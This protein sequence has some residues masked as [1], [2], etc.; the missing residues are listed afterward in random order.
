MRSATEAYEVIV[1]DGG[2]T[3]RG[4]AIAEACGAKIIRAPRGRGRQSSAGADIAA[5]EVLLF[6]H[7]DS[8]L[9]VGFP[10]LVA[11]ALAARGAVWGRFDLRFDEGGV[12]L[13]A[14]ARLI[15]FRSRVSRVAT[16]D[17]AIFVRREAFEAVGGFHEPELFEDIDLCKRLKRYGRIAIPAVPVITSARR[18]RVDGTWSTTSLMWT[19]KLLY[20]AGVPA[21]RLKRFY[22]DTR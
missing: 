9:P 18:W 1:V 22:G 11:D 2:S 8:V 6:L 10:R 16:G 4:T 3:D 19:L 5:G 14:I 20:L 21:S 7:A 15:S 12:V 17:Q 13:R